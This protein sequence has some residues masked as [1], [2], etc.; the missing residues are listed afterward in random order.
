MKWPF[1]WKPAVA[2][3]SHQLSLID[4]LLEKVDPTLVYCVFSYVSVHLLICWSLNINGLLYFSLP[5]SCFKIYDRRVFP[6][7]RVSRIITVF[8]RCLWSLNVYVALTKIL[9]AFLVFLLPHFQHSL[10]FPNINFGASTTWHSVYRPWPF[11]LIYTV[12]WFDKQLFQ[13]L[14]RFKIGS[15]VEIWAYSAN[16]LWYSVYIRDDHSVRSLLGRRVWCALSRLI[17]SRCV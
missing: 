3:L 16:L 15:D 5:L 13:S 1:F 4:I 14:V 9:N 12:F 2:S 6:S 7:Y 10:A 11:H 17:L 8:C